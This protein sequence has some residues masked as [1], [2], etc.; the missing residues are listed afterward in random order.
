MPMNLSYMSEDDLLTHPRVLRVSEIFGKCLQ[1]LFIDLEGK[2]I[3][4]I[5]NGHGCVHGHRY[6]S[7]LCVCV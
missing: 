4:Y 3:L 6:L 5:G 2:D 7:D 1:I